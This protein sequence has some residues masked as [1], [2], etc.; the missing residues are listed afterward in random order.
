[1]NKTEYFSFK[2]RI[3][4]IGVNPFVF[5]PQSVLNKIFKQAG[6]EKGKIPVK[7]KIDGYDFIQTLVKYSGAWRLYLNTPMRKAADKDVGDTAIFEI[8][9]DPDERKVAMHPKLKEALKNNEDAKKVFDRLAPSRQLEILR[10]ISFLKTE[11]SVDK[12]V[13]RAINF[14]LGKE[15]FIARDKP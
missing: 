9:Y 4:I 12:N 6:K 2:T 13:V 10:Y 15:R 3:D 14:L 1:M 7:I 8:R 11:A 5:V